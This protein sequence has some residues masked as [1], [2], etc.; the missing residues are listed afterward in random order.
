MSIVMPSHSCSFTLCSEGGS[1]PWILQ[2]AL[3]PQTFHRRGTKGGKALRSRTCQ[4]FNGPLGQTMPITGS[5]SAV[6]TCVVLP[7]FCPHDAM[8]TLLG[9][10]CNRWGSPQFSNQR[11]RECKFENMKYDKEQKWQIWNGLYVT[12]ET[13]EFLLHQ[14]LNAIIRKKGRLSTHGIDIQPLIYSAEETQCFKSVSSSKS[15]KINR[16]TERSNLV[17]FDSFLGSSFM[18]SGASSPSLSPWPA[19]CQGKKRPT[20]QRLFANCETPPRPLQWPQLFFL[21]GKRGGGL[22]VMKKTVWAGN[23]SQAAGSMDTFFTIFC[24]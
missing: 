5:I 16:L 18:P 17:Y 6:G 15:G 9:S 23:K 14:N 11:M 3:L 10:Q 20:H 22:T 2:F 19:I 8:L 24:K 4:N 1:G 21:K 12:F 13:S 7:L